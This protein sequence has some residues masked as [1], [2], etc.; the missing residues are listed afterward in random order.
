MTP[1]FQLKNI[2][3]IKKSHSSG[4]EVTVFKNADLSI[5]GDGIFVIMGPSG[6][7]KSTLLRFLNRLEDPNEGEIFYQGI[8]INQM[9]I[10]EL[11]QRI[12]MLF[13]LPALPEKTIRENLLFGPALR[14]D[15]PDDKTLKEIME[16]VD[17][18]PDFLD[19]E[20]KRL[21]VGQQQR[22]SLARVLA[23]RPEVL[24]LDE[25]TSSLDSEATVKIEK[26]IKRLVAE[27]GIQA[28]W[29]THHEDQAKRLGK[30]S[31]RIENG[32]IKCE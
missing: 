5:N 12:G 29:V 15:S 13:Q 22:A 30:N 18:D 23:N 17:L 7:G 4:K 21:S 2:T 3:C 6:V 26:T 16:H 28:I 20:A 8:P 11:R 31:A 9:P 19:R 25:P 1:L 14:G 27:D 10:F 32:V 24:L